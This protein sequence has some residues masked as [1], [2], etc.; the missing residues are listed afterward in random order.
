MEQVQRDINATMRGVLVDWMMEVAQEHQMVPETMYLSVMYLDRV[1]SVVPVPQRQ[2]QLYGLTCVMLAS[3]YEELFPAPIDEYVYLADNA[4]TKEELKRCERD[5]LQALKYQLTVPTT[6]PFLKRCL[7]AAQGNSKL[8]FLACYICELSLL[9]Y[10]LLQF[11][12]SQIA[13]S[14]VILAQITLN[15]P[16][17]SCTLSYYTG[18]NKKEL[19]NCV[20]ALHR[21]F[22]NAKRSPLSITTEKYAEHKHKCVSSISTNYSTLPDHFFA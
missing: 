11:L 8:E 18:Y 17:W 13:A 10:G 12:P 19:R 7:Q 21:L 5:V 20:R 22:S 1:L 3:K 16:V 15:Q 14:S 2:L 4:Y 6:R 9:D